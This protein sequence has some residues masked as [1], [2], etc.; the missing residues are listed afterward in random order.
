MTP[1][2][3]KLKGRADTRE[4]I[5]WEN[6]ELISDRPFDTMLEEFKRLKQEFPGRILI[7]SIME[8]RQ[9][10]KMICHHLNACSANILLN[11]ADRLHQNLQSV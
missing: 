9:I 7:A 3:A 2:Y 8:A 1:R 10:A 6:I 11:D 4:V 5:G